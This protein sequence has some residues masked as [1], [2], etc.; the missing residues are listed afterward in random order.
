L[1]AW[2]AGKHGKI[3]NAP[4]IRMG[5][6]NA[7]PRAFVP[8]LTFDGAIPH[9]HCDAVFDRELFAAALTNGLVGVRFD[10]A[11]AERAR[12]FRFI[13]EHNWNIIFD[14]VRASTMIAAEPLFTQFHGSFA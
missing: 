4:R 14:A 7:L 1:T 3:R 5:G 13:D 8:Q 2:R 9:G 6:R 10:L 12:Q 11:C